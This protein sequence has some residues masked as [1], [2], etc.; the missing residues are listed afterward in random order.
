MSGVWSGADIRKKNR[1]TIWTVAQLK[2]FGGI[3]L[4]K[5]ISSVFWNTDICSYGWEDRLLHLHVAVQMH[6]L[7]DWGLPFW[8]QDENKQAGVQEPHSSWWGQ[9]P[10]QQAALCVNWHRCP[11]S[12][13]FTGVL[14][15]QPRV[16]EHQPSGSAGLLC[17]HLSRGSAVMRAFFVSGHIL[18]LPKSSCHCL[19]PCYRR[20]LPIGMEIVVRQLLS[21]N[22]MQIYDTVSII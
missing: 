21:E 10:Q 7:L 11:K 3:Y 19:R 4:A 15:Y 14:N 18:T 16:T 12:L 2:N 22:K 17:K 8:V 13:F 20:D 6:R 1:R 5:V 9:A